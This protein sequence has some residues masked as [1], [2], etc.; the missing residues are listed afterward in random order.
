MT[1][2]HVCYVSGA[3]ALP[4]RKAQSGPISYFT[5]PILVTDNHKLQLNRPQASHASKER[6]HKQVEQCVFS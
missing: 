5:S 3:T 2:G 4:V 1:I 6:P